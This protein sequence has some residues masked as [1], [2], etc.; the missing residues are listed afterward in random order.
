MSIKETPTNFRVY[1][2]SMKE[3]YTEKRKD[4]YKKL[5]ESCEALRLLYEDV[6]SDLKD[7]EKSHNVNLLTYEEFSTNTYI[8]GTFLKVAKGLFTNRKHDYLIVGE[9]FNVYRLAK[10]QYTIYCLNNDI[11]K[12]NKILS[13]T[14]KEYST[15]LKVFY[16]EVHKHLILNGEGYVFEDSIGWTCINRC[17]LNKSRKLIDFMATKR[18]TAELK[19]KGA[20]LYNKEEAE[21]CKRN[22]IEYKFEEKL[23]FK[24]NEYC[25]EIPLLGCKLENGSKY[26]LTISDYRSR[27]VRGKTNLQLIEQCNKDKNKICELDVDLRSKL[28]MCLEADKTLY[29]NFIRNEYQTPINI[30]KIN[31]KN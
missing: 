2:T 22:G 31:R 23:V 15:I 8:D 5:E 28:N 18:K 24:D 7:I 21:W 19:A 10:L 20:R 16:T 13:L 27:N 30:A 11:A 26:K 12:Y 9:L 4:A 1:Y 29:L 14:L 25:Y 3:Q 6:K 17:K